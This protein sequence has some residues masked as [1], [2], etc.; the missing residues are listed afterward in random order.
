[1]DRMRINALLNPE[2]PPLFRPSSPPR[3]P[4]QPSASFASH[5]SPHGGSSRSAPLKSRKAFHSWA[6]RQ[7]EDLKNTAFYQDVK[8]AFQDMYLP[9]DLPRT[10]DRAAK[11]K[12]L[13]LPELKRAKEGQPHKENPLAGSQTQHSIGHRTARIYGLDRDVWI[14]ANNPQRAF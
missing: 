1:M 13:L 6:R 7:C 10:A 11:F 2:D 9:D 14:R 8:A 4:V 12:S 5:A 3:A